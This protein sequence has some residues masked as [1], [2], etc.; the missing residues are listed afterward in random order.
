MTA[1]SSAPSAAPSAPSALPR[2]PHASV[3]GLLALL[4]APDRAALA[5]ADAELEASARRHALVERGHAA[6]WTEIAGRYG[7]PAAFQYVPET[8]AC[9]AQAG[10]SPPIEDAADTDALE[11]ADVRDLWPVEDIA[12][13]DEE[14]AGE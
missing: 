13:D 2:A 8:G 4:D 1:R 12:G 10:A 14:A 7:L 11:A 6:L 3:A 9:Y 5:A